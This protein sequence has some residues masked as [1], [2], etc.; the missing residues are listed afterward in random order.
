MNR[1]QLMADAVDL[2]RLG[3]DDDC[4]LLGCGVPL[5]SAFGKLDYC[6]IGCDVGLD[7]DDM[8]PMRF[9]HRE[10]V[11]TKNAI[12]NTY[13]RRPLNGRAFGNDPDVFFLRDDVKL[14]V[15]QRDEL[16]FANADSGTVLLT[17]DDMGS[18]TPDQRM[19]YQLALR[20]LC[21]KGA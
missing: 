9:L 6:R 19:R 10:R 11:S 7:W 17:S 13:G 2:C 14:T 8:P 16:L 4:L 20:I 3:A 5:S 12:G 15:E 1:G 18:W 21:K